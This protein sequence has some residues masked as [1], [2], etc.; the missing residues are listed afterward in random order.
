M[1]LA[2]L[3]APA[4]PP[5][6][7][8]REAWARFSQLAFVNYSWLSFEMWRR[9]I[10]A[11]SRCDSM[12]EDPR[13]SG[14]SSQPF[15]QRSNVL[16]HVAGSPSAA[17]SAVLHSSPQFCNLFAHYC[18]RGSRSQDPVPAIWLVHFPFRPNFRFRAARRLDPAVSDK[19]LCNRGELPPSFT[20]PSMSATAPHIRQAQG[21]LRVGI[22]NLSPVRGSTWEGSDYSSSVN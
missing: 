11:I 20:M 12:A 22:S 9:K 19:I 14:P 13:C 4:S 15:S 21:S 6:A 3:P 2:P 17:W 5:A 18:R 1:P 10:A 7:A 16:L 8:S